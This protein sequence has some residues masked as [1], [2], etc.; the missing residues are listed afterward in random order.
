[1]SKFK[2]TLWVNA[3]VKKCKDEFGRDAL[4]K[5]NGDIYEMWPEARCDKIDYSGIKYVVVCSSWNELFSLQ[6]H[7][8]I[9]NVALHLGS[10]G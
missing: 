6:V 5:Y 2:M 7:C 3:A 10:S 9:S 4:T 8:F 1:M